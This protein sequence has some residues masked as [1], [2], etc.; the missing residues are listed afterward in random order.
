VA[1]LERRLDLVPLAVGQALDR[2]DLGAVGLDGEHAARLHGLAVELH[3]AG[4]AVAGVAPDGSADLAGSFSQVVD[5]EQPRFDLVLA[6][7]AVDGQG[8]A[9]H[10]SSFARR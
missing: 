1:L 6:L 9:D 2:G 5:E 7:L 8:D 3:G 10:A 4:T